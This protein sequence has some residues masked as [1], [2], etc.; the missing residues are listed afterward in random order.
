MKQRQLFYK[1]ILIETAM[2]HKAW[3]VQKMVVGESD[4][5]VTLFL[6]NGR[7]V[8]AHAKSALKRDSKLRAH[9]E[10]HR[11]VEVLLTGNAFKPTLAECVAISSPLTGQQRLYAEQ[12]SMVLSAFGEAMES[13]DVVRLLESAFVKMKKN[14][15]LERSLHNQILHTLFSLAGVE[16]VLN[17]CVECG[18]IESGV[19]F[20]G[21]KNGGVTCDNCRMEGDE[22]LPAQLSPEDMSEILWKHGQFF[23][24]KPLKNKHQVA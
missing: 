5:L 2:V 13:N 18:K 21:A 16:I 8:Q 15:E 11:V 17:A 3:I 10:P 4:I 19:W 14:S 9:L 12:Y 7:R 20:Y 23:A 6:A 22:E 1:V 24:V